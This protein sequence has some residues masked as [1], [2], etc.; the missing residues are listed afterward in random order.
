MS[1]SSPAGC[2]EGERFVYESEA[3]RMTRSRVEQDG[4]VAEVVHPG[5]IRS[6]WRQHRDSSHGEVHEHA[7]REVPSHVPRYKGC[8]PILEAAYNMAMNEVEDNLSPEGLFFSG[9]N[10]HHAWT[11]DTAFAVHLALALV[12]P[13]HSMQSL[14]S[15]VADGEV[16][17]DTGTGGSWPVSTDR[18]SWA[19]AAWEVFLATGDR[20]WL[21]WSADVLRRT[22]V[23]DEEVVIDQS[24]LIRGES[25]FLDWREQ[26][27]PDWMSPVDIAES[28]SLSTMA[29]HS[30]ARRILSWMCREQGQ[31]EEAEAW[32]EEA[33][34][35]AD[36]LNDIFWMPA[37]G[38]YGQYL[39]G[40][41]Y[42]VLSP[43][44]DALGEAFCVLFGIAGG[45]HA[46]RVVCRMPHGCFGVPTFD[47]FKSS[48]GDCYHNHAV[49]PFVE[50]YA[51]RAAAEVGHMGAVARNMACLLR[52]VLLFGTN[53][54]NF[55]AESGDCFDTV[56]NSDRQL[57]SVAATL[58]MFYRAL[59]GLVWDGDVLVFAPC[60]PKEYSGEHWLYGLRLRSFTLDVHIHGYGTE[61]CRC[62]INGKDAPPIIS[63]RATGHFVVELEVN[64][65]DRDGEPALAPASP[66]DLQEPAWVEDEDA[67]EWHPVER[68]AYYRIYRNG[69][70]IT[71]QTALRYVPVAEPHYAQY[72]VQAVSYGGRESFL[73]APREH[74]LPN[75]RY[76][77]LPLSIGRYGEY[78]VEG[79]QAWLDTQPHTR[80]LVYHDLTLAES[81]IYRVEA[82][83][84]NATE[85][86]RDGDTCAIRSLFVDDK[87]E[88]H[89]VMPQTGEAGD[90]EHYTHTSALEMSLESGT[91]RFQIRYTES[92]R[93]VNGG[94]NQ[95]MVRHLRVTRIG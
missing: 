5:L 73:N 31:A 81:G 11:R 14:R 66:A 26:S 76:C 70:P 90:W 69:I 15:R 91:H 33:D 77:V 53:K 24:G 93:N 55:S 88:G 65:V 95:A 56:L 2:P 52:A 22:L 32:D 20:E 46:E 7:L 54:E 75:S 74:L 58:G 40:R 68:A 84:C 86:R 85:S 61:V 45:A 3:F 21:A 62:M 18:V 59:F 6:T 38:Q 57:W 87:F 35:L 94:T 82:W 28:F 36:L 72:Q 10:W 17:Q 48:V 27:Y 92:D 64:P 71:Q 50:G 44:S 25:S 9:A 63:A 30:Q 16:V 42:P 4:A 51:L 39:Y 37:R 34:K 80:C 83:F 89:L 43:R 49:W 79:G 47:P 60:V 1:D 67:L 8:F 12:D 78:P 19:L 41:G 29:L 13:E 23:H